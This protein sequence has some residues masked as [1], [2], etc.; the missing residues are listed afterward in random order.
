MSAN[1]VFI[2][3]DWKASRMGRTRN[4]NMEK[5]ASTIGGVVR[6]MTPAVICMCEVGEAN[7]PLDEE[8]MNHVA[9]ETMVAGKD[10]ATEH[11]RLRSMFETG[12][13][14]MTVYIDG[15]IECSDH[16]ILL[17]LYDVG[18]MRREAEH[19]FVANAIWQIGFPPLPPFATEQRR[20]PPA[21]PRRDPQ[22]SAQ[23]LEAV[24]EAIRS[25]LD[26]L[27]RIATVL[28][29]HRTMPEY[30]EARR[31]SG[32][33]HG[34]SGLSATEQ[35]TRAAIRKAKFDMRTAKALAEQWGDY[36]LTWD[37]CSLW[38]KTL[39]HAYWDGSLRQRLN[40]VTSQG[41]ADPMCRTPSLA[42]HFCYR[43]SLPLSSA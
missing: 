12:Y 14:Y 30:Q 10:A 15:P 20:A 36:T 1:L 16:R 5:L 22:L 21:G 29:L 24:P 9:A 25:V 28:L 19:V 17:H 6:S 27:D 8:Q 35:K 18:K 26:W 43:T 33:A 7:N 3:I 38:R 32:V 2:N 41:S 39:L 37:T 42:N 31:K 23:D 13:P 4:V 40:E 34:Q 11:I